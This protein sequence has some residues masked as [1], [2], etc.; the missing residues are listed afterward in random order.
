[1]F[2]ALIEGDRAE[3][4]AAYQRCL[5]EAD[6]PIVR[7]SALRQQA[8]ANGAQILTDVTRSIR[9][10]KIHV[11]DNHK[12]IA[13]DMGETKAARGLHSR[14]TVQAAMV[15]FRVAVT[16]MARHV[17]ADTASFQLFMIVL[18]AMNQSISMRIREATNA[19]SGF[20]LSRIHEA[21]LGERHRIARELHDRVGNVLGVAHRQLELYHL[22]QDKAPALTAKRLEKIQQSIADSIESLRTVTSELHPQEPMQSLEKALAAYLESS[23]TGDVALH[24]RINGDER[25]ASPAVRD[26]TF[27]VL[28]EAIHNA[29][30]HGGPAMVIVGMD[31][32][33]TRPRRCPLAWGCCP[34]ASERP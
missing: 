34:C 24:L 25:W 32:A 30:N 4:L 23:R 22:Q 26:E 27:L 20:L 12:V 16:H 33:P 8:I 29:L 21:H 11:D 2:A 28:R 13:W 18:L 31:I 17:A 6:S 1:M 9:V 19:Y 3:I 10:G 5:E 15:F 14:D 7:E